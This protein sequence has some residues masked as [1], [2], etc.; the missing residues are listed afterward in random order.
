M[1][2]NAG[3]SAVTGATLADAFP[4]LI[5]AA[6]WT[7]AGAGGATC[8]AASGTG[9][10]NASVNLPVGGSLTYTV[11]ATISSAGGNLVNTA[12][13]TAPGGTT[14][15]ALGNNT[16]AD[17]DTQTTARADIFVTKSG[18]ASAFR[19]DPATYTIVFGNAGPSNVNGVAITDTFPAALVGPTWTC[20]ASGG[21]AC[22]AASGSGNIGATVNLPRGSRLT[23]TATAT[24]SSTFTG[25]LTNT[26]GVTAPAIPP[27]PVFAN[28]FASVTTVVVAQTQNADVSV[29]KTGTAGPV[30]VGS[31]VT[32]SIAVTNNGP[33]TAQNV[34]L[35]DPLP[36][37]TTWISTTTSVG[38]CTGSS[39]VTCSFGPLA[40]GATATV[41]IVAR[42]DAFGTKSNTV[43]VANPN[44]SDY[45]PNTT[46][47]VSTW[48]TTVSGS[49]TCGTPGGPGPGGTLTGVVNTYYPASASVAA[50][51]ANTCIPVGA[52][53]GA[54]VGI[55]SGD[56]LLVVQM[57][58][59]T[60]DSSNTSNYG[61]GVGTGAGALVV[62]A[63]KYEYVIARDVI[64]GGGCAASQVPVTGTGTNG[65]LLNSYTNSDASGTKGQARYQVVRV[66]QYST[67]T[68]NGVAALP[69]QTDN[70]DPTGCTTNGLGWG[71]IVAL[72][73]SGTLTISGG[74]AANVDGLGFRGAAGRRLTGGAGANT[75]YRTL[76]TIT[77]NGGKGEGSAGTP[78]WVYDGAGTSRVACTDP[79][80]NTYV[81]QTF[82]PNDGYPNGSM[83]RGAP[84]N[85]GGGSTDDNPAANDRNSGGGGGSN[86]GAG[87]R[88]G[89]SW[90]TAL[91]RGGLGAAVVPAISQLVL[92]GGGGAGTRNNS[93]CGGPDTVTGAQDAQASSGAAG[94]GLIAIRAGTLSVPALATLSANGSAAFNDTARDGGGGGGAGGSIVLTVTD[95]ATSMANLTL[96]ANGGRGGDAWRTEPPDG[97][98]LGDRHGPGGGGG[99]GVVAYTVTAGA[100]TV[101]VAG[102]Q[103]GITTSANDTFGAL[104]GRRR[105]DA[106]RQPGP[107]PRRR[108]RRGVPDARP[109][110][111]DRALAHG[112]DGLGR[113]A[114]HD[115][116]QRHEREPGDVRPRQPDVRA[117]HGDD[118]ARHGLTSIVVTSAPGWTCGVAGQVVTCTRTT[119]LAPRE[120]FPPIQVSATVATN[121]VGP[122]TLTN[123]ATVSGGGDVN[124]ENNTATDSIGVRAPT[125]AHL[126]VFEALR[127]GRVVV[128]RWRTSYE[129]NNLGFR[130]YREAGGE[131]ELVTPR[132]LAG[133]AFA[134]GKGRPLPSGRSYA[135]IDREPL[136]DARYWLEDIDLDGSKTWTGPVVAED[137]PGE[138]GWG[139]VVVP[140]PSP[141]LAGLGREQARRQRWEGPRGIGLERRERPHR[142][143]DGRGEAWTAPSQPAA[144]LLV[145]REGWYR[146]TKQE[147]LAA[148]FDPGTAPSSLRLLAD[149]VEQ[150]I[151]VNDGADGSF[152]ATDSVEFYGVGFDSPWDGAHV[153]WLLS[154]RPGARIGTG[155]GGDA[156]FPPA[157][158]SFP[159]TVE[160]RE[161][162]VQIF[163]LPETGDE[164]NFFGAIVTS[165]PVLQ[166][167]V[168]TNVDR[169]WPGDATV[170]LALQGGLNAPHR[171]EV[172][173]NGSDVGTVE[174]DGQDRAVQSLAAP[175]AWL[176]EGANEVTLA[177]AAG[178]EDVSLVDYVRITYPHLY[179]LDDGAVRMTAPG[180]SRV[181]LDGL[182]DRSLRV[183][184]LSRP[185][186]PR[187]LAVS[188]AS[189]AA[190]VRARFA[191][192]A[193]A[194]ATLYAFTP[195]R[196]LSPPAIVPN[197][198]SSWSRRDNAADFLIVGHPTLLAG[199]EPLRQLRSRQGL[200]TSIVDVTDVYDEFAYG[201][202]TPYAIR[203][204]LQRAALTWRRPPRYVLL[205]G[206]ASF[207]PRNYLGEGDFDLV[208]A[209][210]V[211]TAYMKT[212]S[213]DW[214]VDWDGDGVPE[215]AIGR[216]PA[217]T[218]AEASTMVAKIVASDAATG[219]PSG[220]TPEWAKR[221][222]FVSGPADDYD[223]PAASA[224]L[225]ALLPRGM[226]SAEVAIG[227]LGPAA[228]REAIVSGFNAGQL[229]VNFAGHASTDV[230]MER[231][232]GGIVF[233]GADA[234][235]LGSGAALVVS[236][237]CLN[238]L[239]DDLWTESLAE[240]LLKSPAGG[241]AAVWASSGLTEPS[242]QAPMN[243][244]LF[245]L[246]F[247]GAPL[248]VGDAMVRAKA[249]TSDLDVRRTWILFGDP[250]MRLR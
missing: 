33:A 183:V 162:T 72:D 74:V 175:V 134:V 174:F 109:R 103:P 178:D 65:G 145:A 220:T 2:A 147:L 184:D 164:E 125:L 154:D 82:Q 25:N 78:E 76:S 204:F 130:V 172:K 189:S 11:V 170:E 18:P 191:V 132:I 249:A 117:G 35:S 151:L 120:S 195:G 235:A 213:D 163:G 85:A 113:R 70:C 59:A 28:N 140:A 29:A 87:G 225:R 137:G 20:V 129:M 96:R 106:H 177:G 3:P 205:A 173:L 221:V 58:D 212:D 1:A 34:T 98:T 148:G 165:E 179:A 67:A 206:D 26:A 243:E 166:S 171:V 93:N 126:R 50:G 7:C 217:R 157:P 160:L 199:L 54:A 42:V 105:P 202:K 237:T 232:D 201:Q 122:T 227:P 39:I 75:D 135:W 49:P 12:T 200:V 14:D 242:A 32:W 51:Q 197:E 240:D 37:G 15:P 57:Q 101:S 158:S 69:W 139:P 116:R 144:K 17:T 136:G 23:Y 97:N 88:G 22:P 176:R 143:A 48:L 81:V 13:I 16:A 167:L 73:V 66:P 41:T 44:G 142:G 234:G 43:T 207:D 247:S 228:A 114:G 236:M 108:L 229:L 91:D 86:G 141:A 115:L 180:L 194:E 223:F 216:L 131:R 124:P 238:G 45:D 219:R 182:A 111:D 100:P 248:R 123:T 99:G 203:D 8:P 118:H 55:S 61:G 192:P 149:G 152:D 187:E 153:Y 138:G 79:A 89:L 127:R 186:R 193:G 121:V 102:G 241:A 156:P 146:V 155:H 231:A 77:T 40:N 246:L 222:L 31:N 250:T 19:G 68:L 83:A 181:T 209:K 169:Q 60:I 214:Y 210:L 53:R 161:R 159:F 10:I 119:A 150:A 5:T 133:S 198:A 196:V 185:S 63:G 90:S 224:R 62:N 30:A 52:A 168:L 239:F 84:G 218:A 188:F 9:A 94:G 112:D 38:T 244:E 128:L 230:W 233:S 46:N 215:L 95:T 24:I 64:G 47:N 211:R 4:A 21:A 107:D 27:D 71:G 245:R 208:P 36:A 6:S 92:G 226:R 110:P 104:P 80:L 56:V 190:G